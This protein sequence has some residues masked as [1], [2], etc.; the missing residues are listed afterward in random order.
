MVG[1]TYPMSE[2]PGPHSRKVTNMVKARLQAIAA[3]LCE[4]NENNRVKIARLNRY[5]P[6]TTEMQMRQKLKVRKEANLMHVVS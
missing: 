2:V 4:K 3:R 6:T 5:F 1:Q